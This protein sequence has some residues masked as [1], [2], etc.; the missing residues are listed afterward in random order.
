MS[1]PGERWD[2]EAMTAAEMWLKRELTSIKRE[3]SQLGLPVELRY[4][5]TAAEGGVY[6]LTIKPEWWERLAQKKAALPP[7][8]E[9]PDGTTKGV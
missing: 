7:E 3:A 8:E 4:Q 1:E 9:R 5:M 2:W 6:T